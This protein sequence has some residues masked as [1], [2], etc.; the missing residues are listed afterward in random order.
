MVFFPM[1]FLY[2]CETGSSG[3]WM[4]EGVVKGKGG[5]DGGKLLLCWGRA[6]SS[7]SARS[8]DSIFENKYRRR[9]QKR[10]GALIVQLPKR[11][12]TEN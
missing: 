1:G 10:H 8:L 6:R 12:L 7:R 11:G 3:S 4:K 5:W 2:L 9:C